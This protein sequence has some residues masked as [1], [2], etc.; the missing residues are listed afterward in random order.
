MALTY[1]AAPV[2]LLASVGEDAFA[3][4]DGD[5][6]ACKY[7]V[8]LADERIFVFITVLY[9][10]HTVNPEIFELELSCH[11]NGIMDRVR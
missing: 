9:D 8:H 11:K 3:G 5:L 6:S 7:L 1:A 4:S 2:Q 10:T